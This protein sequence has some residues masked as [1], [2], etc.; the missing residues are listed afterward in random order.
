MFAE[1]EKAIGEHNKVHN[2]SGVPFKGEKKRT[3]AEQRSEAEGAVSLEVLGSTAEQL[4]PE[5]K[6]PGPES[7]FEVLVKGND[8]YL[9]GL[10]DGVVSARQPVAQFWGRY[11][12]GSTDKKDIAKFSQ[13]LLPWQMNSKD[14]EACFQVESS[15]TDPKLLDFPQH[16]QSL[17]AF[18]R[19]LEENA[20]VGVNI[21][22][23]ELYKVHPK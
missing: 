23:H 10:A 16:A 9:H 17:V 3:D 1:V 2:P 4:Q 21:E 11:L 19:H 18:L 8:L 14:F 20:V 22:V 12:C 7:H 15:N 13:H 6:L 5:W